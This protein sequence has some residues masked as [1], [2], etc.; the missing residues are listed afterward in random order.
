M[1]L[2]SSGSV[3]SVQSSV[4]LI[5]LDVLSLLDPD[6]ECLET[7]E[8][9]FEV[10]FSVSEPDCAVVVA[11]LLFSLPRPLLERVD[12]GSAL[13]CPGVDDLVESRPASSQSSCA[14]YRWTFM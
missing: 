13:R 1:R 2:L 14:S 11:L 8:D 9:I 10:S 4:F 5:L 3:T 6:E 7:L 12:G